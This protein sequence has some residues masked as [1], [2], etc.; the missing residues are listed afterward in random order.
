MK[1]SKKRRKRSDQLGLS[2]KNI[3][4]SFAGSENMNNEDTLFM[5]KTPKEL[6]D[7]FSCQ[8]LISIEE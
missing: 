3:A 4:V 1:A 2:S 8:V 5:Y 7:K 6:I